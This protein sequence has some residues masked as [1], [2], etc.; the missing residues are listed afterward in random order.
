MAAATGTTTSTMTTAS[1]A[2]AGTKRD[3]TQYQFYG[4]EMSAAG[5]GGEGCVS[6]NPWPVHH[7]RYRS[8]LCRLCTSCVLRS[9]PGSFCPK[10]FDLIDASCGRSS[11]QQQ[12]PLAVVHC[13]S[14][15]SVCHTA[16]LSEAENA[17]SYV[18]PSCANPNGYSYFPL[19]CDS[20]GDESLPVDGQGKRRMD[21]ESAKVLLAAARLASA[22]MHKAVAVARSAADR[23]AKDA[24]VARKKAKEMLEKVLMAGKSERD[25]RRPEE[26]SSGPAMPESQGKTSANLDRAMSSKVSPK[27]MQNRDRDRWMGLQDPT[28]LAQQSPVLAITMGEAGK[29][30]LPSNPSAAPDLENKGSPMIPGKIGIVQAS[31]GKLTVDS[32]RAVRKVAAETGVVARTPPRKQGCADLRF[33][34]DFEWI[35]RAGAPIS[36]DSEGLGVKSAE[37]CPTRFEVWRVIR[38]LVTKRDTHFVNAIKWGHTLT[39]YNLPKSTVGS[40]CRLNNRMLSLFSRSNEDLRVS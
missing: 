4:R 19:D 24:V 38:L 28:P 30:P 33:K 16:C 36:S 25:Q 12:L 2:S 29:A 34:K 31:K 37:I 7:V 40:S 10:C 39:L 1:V 18:C 21:L 27:N 32:N 35:S 15:T 9:H 8:N 6:R 20:E 23:K 11:Q 3:Q 26:L 17:A 13:V 14:C 5:C 22:S